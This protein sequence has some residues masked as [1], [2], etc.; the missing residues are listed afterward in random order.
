MELISLKLP[1]PL[2]A[3]L[4]AEAK[5][6]RVSQSAIVRESLQATLAGRPPGGGER[7]CADL[8]GELVGALSGPRDL[9]TNERY[10]QIEL[11]KGVRPGRKRRR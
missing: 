9:S 10:L 1:A 8:A 7:S 5:R 3:K 11:L 4:A 2:R 6:R